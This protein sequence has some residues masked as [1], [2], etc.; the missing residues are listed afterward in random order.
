[1]N[2]QMILVSSSP[3]SSTTGFFTLIFAMFGP[4]SP[5]GRGRRVAGAVGPRRRPSGG[6]DA[7]DRWRDGR[8][9][10]GA[11]CDTPSMA[12]LSHAT[13]E[14]AAPRQTHQGFNQAP[15]LEGVDVFSSNRPLGQATQRAGAGGVL[16]RASA[17]GPFARG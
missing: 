15:P 2:S 1:M 12:T 7:I 6:A 13:G 9:S 5:C 11:I 10:A 14:S 4:W 8:E 3:S 16:A 17:R